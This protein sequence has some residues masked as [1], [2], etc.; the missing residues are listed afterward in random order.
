MNGSQYANLA[1]ALPSGDVSV[2]NAA[3]DGE[4]SCG[5]RV[6]PSRGVCAENKKMTISMIVFIT[7]CFN[8]SFMVV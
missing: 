2:R 6:E 7:I 8:L 4:R 3:R 1:F 5:Q